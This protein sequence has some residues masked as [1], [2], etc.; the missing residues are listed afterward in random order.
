MERL[1]YIGVFSNWCPL[2]VEST[3][4]FVGKSE[5]NCFFFF[6]FFPLSI[7]LGSSML[8]EMCHLLFHCS[9]AEPLSIYRLDH[10]RRAAGLGGNRLL[11]PPPRCPRTQREPQLDACVSGRGGT[12]RD[13][14]LGRPR[15]RWSA[16]SA[17]RI[18]RAL[19]TEPPLRKPACLQP[20][21]RCPAN[22]RM[23]R[24]RRHRLNASKRTNTHT[25]WELRAR[26]A[27]SSASRC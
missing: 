19:I 5:S 21:R 8:D 11:P 24:L 17:V 6:F 1:V 26:S 7:Y 9:P 20:M 3:C 27:Q 12:M 22:P 14:G 2:K 18:P 10:R 25:P 16:E 23:S 15:P 4:A 13:E